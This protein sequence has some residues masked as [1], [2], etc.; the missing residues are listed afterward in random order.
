VGG[1]DPGAPLLRGLPDNQARAEAGDPPQARDRSC[2]K[3]PDPILFPYAATVPAVEDARAIANP[4]AHV[5]HEPIVMTT[6]L[7]ADAKFWDFK[8]VHLLTIL[9][10]VAVGA[11]N[12][13]A[14]DRRIGRDEDNIGRV[15]EQVKLL[16]EQ[17]GRI[18]MSG[19]QASQRGMLRDADASASGVHRLE[20][21]EKSVSE[22][23]P[24]MERI[25]TNV[26]WI[27]KWI[28]TQETAKR[29]K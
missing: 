15:I 3:R 20:V 17:V 1:D 12:F 5:E 9:G 27:T 18:D 26:D 28:Q 29:A 19:T 16:T 23:G 24:R 7:H 2:Y 25:D 14:F 22:M 21:L 4:A 8:L 13:I 6:G 11:S 10:M